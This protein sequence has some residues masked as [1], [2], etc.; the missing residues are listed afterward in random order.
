MLVG[1]LDF[2]NGV[3]RQAVWYVSGC[4]QV[5][6]DQNSR[7]ALVEDLLAFFPRI[8]LLLRPWVG[9]A[10]DTIDGGTSSARH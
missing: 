2:A 1:D 8:L 5:G 6:G 10:R 4:K 9:E 7:A 3:L